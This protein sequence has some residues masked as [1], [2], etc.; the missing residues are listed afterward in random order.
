MKTDLLEGRISSTVSYFHLTRENRVLRFRET[1]LDGSFPTITRQGTVDESKGVE[2]EVTW[3]PTNNWQVYA[4]Y[5][6][7]DIKTT[8]ALFP[9]IIVNAD[10]IFQAAYVTAYNEAIGLV[11]NAV[12]EGSAEHLSSHRLISISRTKIVF[13]FCPSRSM[14]REAA[15][16]YVTNDKPFT[17]S[18]LRCCEDFN[19]LNR[20][21]GCFQLEFF[22]PVG[23]RHGITRQRSL[24]RYTIWCPDTPN[25]KSAARVGKR[26]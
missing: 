4:T 12:P 5:N 23:K 15:I 11:L 18:K 7:M 2:M 26:T 17:T 20:W 21:F 19:T 6:A 9:A 24:F 1:A 8:K 13:A 10:P 22:Q 16:R 3:S 14:G 25:K